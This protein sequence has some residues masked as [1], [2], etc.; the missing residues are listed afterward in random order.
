VLFIR[1]VTFMTND[2][3]RLADFWSAALAMPERRD[4]AEETICADAEWRYPRLTF[5]KVGDS[6][7]RIARR[8]HLDLTADD[9]RAEV[10]R[11]GSLGATEVREVSMDDG[12][13]WTVMRDP[14]GNEFCVTDP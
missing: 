2:P 4:D 1:N 7:A 6:E 10:A 11:L 14:D 5:Q 12:W 3:R 9:R 8:L 13:S